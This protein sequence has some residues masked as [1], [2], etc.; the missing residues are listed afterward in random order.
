[1]SKEVERITMGP[2]YLAPNGQYFTYVE[3]FSNGALK[4]TARREV[5]KEIIETA[6]LGY[7][8]TTKDDKQKA[9]AK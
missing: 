4:G 6:V 7:V 1:M 3:T 5:P 8:T 9:A 2:L